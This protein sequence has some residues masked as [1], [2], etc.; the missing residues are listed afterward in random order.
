MGELF[1][2]AYEVTATNLETGDSIATQELRCSF[3]VEKGNSARGNTATI[4][5][6]N[7]SPASRDAITVLDTTEG[8]PQVQVELE[9]G[10]G[11][12]QKLLFRGT[13]NS[14]TVWQ[15]PN[16]VT[17]FNLSDGVT[18]VTNT[19]FN[20]AYP[21]LTKVDV[22]VQDVL[23]ASDLQDGYIF[24]TEKVISVSPEVNFP[25]SNKILIIVSPNKKNKKETG[26][27]INRLTLTALEIL[28]PK[29]EYSPRE[30]FSENFG[31]MTVASAT[32]TIEI[33]S[34]KM[35]NP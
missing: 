24:K 15:A 7:L 13:G 27:K 28:A 31:K 14:Q 16:F 12:N 11:E 8:T 4:S 23:K 21:K 32:E 9:A 5:L 33:G 35:F 1:R 26:I 25:L 34:T 20:K 6:Y 2:R 19:A 3:K 18:S 22:I 17:T 30:I 29:S 10:Y